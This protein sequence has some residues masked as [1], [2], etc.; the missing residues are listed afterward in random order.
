MFSSGVTQ[1]KDIEFGVNLL[2]WNDNYQTCE[3]LDMRNGGCAII[4]QD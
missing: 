4:Y 2:S 3:Q 1:Y